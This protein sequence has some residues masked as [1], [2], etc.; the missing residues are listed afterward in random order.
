MNKDGTGLDG[1]VLLYDAVDC[2]CKNSTEFVDQCASQCY[3]INQD[4]M[5]CY[6]ITYNDR[7]ANDR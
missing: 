6:F 5:I 2:G 1:I 4:Q 7:I 3:D